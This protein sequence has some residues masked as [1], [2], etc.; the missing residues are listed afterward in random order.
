MRQKKTRPLSVF[1]CNVLLQNLWFLLPT[2]MLPPPPPPSRLFLNHLKHLLQTTL[3][4]YKQWIRIIGSHK[5]EYDMK[6]EGDRKECW[7]PC[8]RTQRCCANNPNIVWC[9][10]LCSCARNAAY[11]CVSWKWGWKRNNVGSV[12]IALPTL[13]GLHMR[14]THCPFEHNSCV[15]QYCR[16]NSVNFSIILL[17]IQTRS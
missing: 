16:Q 15:S 3:R 7:A 13:L 17:L 10:T 4:S 1:T 2:S 8:K 14:I 6:N 11:C 5:V 12:C 9:Y